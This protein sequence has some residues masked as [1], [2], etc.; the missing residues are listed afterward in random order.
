MVSCGQLAAAPRDEMTAPFSE[1][2]QT[3]RA[4]V[5][6]RH[7][8]LPLRFI[9]NAGQMDPAVRF[10]VKRAGHTIFFAPDEVVFRI[11][12]RGEE[13]TVPASSVVRL[14]FPGANPSPRVE[15][16]VRLP[17]RAN[18][19]LGDNPAKWR[20]DVPTFGGV[21]Y[22]NLYP[23][24]DLL[25]GGTNG[26][27]KS[28]FRVAPAAS[29]ERI[30]MSYRHVESMSLRED[31]ALVLETAKGAWIE[32]APVVYQ[33]IDG[34][35]VEVEGGYH[36]LGE[37]QVG[38]ALGRYDPAYALV[39]DPTLI[40]STYL[41]GS[42]S[43]WEAGYDIA[44]DST[45]NAYVTGHTPS[46]DF[47]TAGAVQPA[48]GGGDRD[49]F[50][51]KLDAAGSSIVYST[52]LGGSALD[53]GWGIAVDTAGNAYVTGV[54]ASSDFPTVL[55][56]Q[57][58]YGGGNWD[59]FV[60]KLDPAGSAIIYSTYLGG[61]DG[62][63]GF[64]IAVD[65]AGSAYVS[66]GAGDDF[67][68]ALPL[69]PAHGGAGD[70]FVTKL[71]PAGFAFVY[72]T[73]LGGSG[74]DK[75]VGIAVDTAG[76]ASVTGIT[77]S[78]DFP[79]AGAIQPAFGGGLNDAFMTKINP[80]GSALVYSTYLG[81]SDMDWG[82]SI[83]VDGAGS[84]YATGVTHSPDFPT[85]GA[86]QPA[87]GGGIE[88]AF[89][90][91][92]D[93]AGSALVYSTYLGGSGNDRGHG[94]A[95]DSAGIAYLTGETG[96]PDFPAMACPLQPGFGGGACD[97]FVTTLDAAGSALV[98][99]SY[100][101]GS[102]EDSGMG[103]AVDTAGHAYVTGGT[104]SP[105][106]F[107]TALPLQPVLNGVADV[108]VAKVDDFLL[109]IPEA[110]GLITV[111]KDPIGSPTCHLTWTAIPDAAV[112]NLYRGSQPGLSN[113][114]NHTCFESSSPDT[115]STDTEGPA[116]GS[117]LF[118]YLVSGENACWDEGGLGTDSAGM[119]RPNSAPCP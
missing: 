20:T 78:F 61:S 117:L 9:S 99:S 105:E 45:G 52:Y 39:I 23:G 94:I 74:I 26:R 36:L 73:Y 12:S 47:P 35:H 7:G 33:E 14:C 89:V 15:G 3:V 56:I 25:Y 76:N 67:P 34:K 41:G 59:A 64:G 30:R 63:H 10:Q 5:S 88:D 4:R 84:A 48:Y 66:G 101:G 37:G 38:F 28:E 114:Y 29:P 109:P 70:A 116:P 69:Q 62:D 79:M 81:G 100:L 85:A 2:G 87:L 21:A 95:V 72:S 24:I 16:L 49:V 102:A 27:L 113:A 65:T 57:P 53:C 44:V 1:V 112:Y 50:V 11:T 71:N 19:F 96:S 54:T 55:P 75:G 77:H 104:S 18:F 103:I 119:D 8:A 58:A 110:G 108:F 92:L 83:T 115:A 60:T 97:A 46:D 43:D 40:F 98:Y 22:R 42:S 32:E 111:T 107:P 106:D 86:V 93:A 82:L 68:L 51:T 118:Y 91:K 6:D 17:G 13:E 31:G 80:P 90:T